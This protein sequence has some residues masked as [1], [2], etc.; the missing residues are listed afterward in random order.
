MRRLFFLLSF[1]VALTA[2]QDDSSDTAAE[3]PVRGLKTVLIEE[4]E[5]TTI[6]RYPSV[7][8]PGSISSLSFEI[9]GRLQEINLDVG[10][11]V[12]EGDVIAEI[13]TRSLELQVETAEA[14]LQESKSLAKN[15]AEDAKRKEELRKKGIVSDSVADKARTDAETSAARVVQAERNLETA[16][17]NLGKAKLVAP[18]DGIINSVEVQSFANVGVGAAIATIY[19]ID[20]FESSFSVSFDIVNRL[21]VGKKV[22]VR[23]ADNPEIALDGHIS[24]LGARADTVSSFP[25]VVKLDEIDPSIK[26]GMAVEIS[27]EFTVPSGEGFTLPLSVLPFDGKLEPPKNPSDPGR[28]QVFV[29]NPDNSTVSRRDVVVAGVRENAIIIIDGLKLGERVASAGVSFLREGQK[30]K[31]LTD[32]D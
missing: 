20:A 32:A 22:R 8:Q 6:R 23:L 14:A 17:E 1:C 30:V 16:N 19:A 12:K 31:L 9:G 24:E 21:T 5:Q 2:C 11:R 15:A 4:T 26:A 25:V 29:F 3:A 13:D 28:T 7:L 10:Q 18:F 27:I